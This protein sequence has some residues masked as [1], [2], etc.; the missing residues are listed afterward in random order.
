MFFL[1]GV[2]NL[3]KK[4]QAIFEGGPGQQNSCIGYQYTNSLSNVFSMSNQDPIVR[5]ICGKKKNT[6]DGIQ[7]L[8]N[9]FQED[10]SKMNYYSIVKK[11]YCAT[12]DNS[13]NKSLEFFDKCTKQRVNPMPSFTKIKN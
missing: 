11:G 5:K 13:I 8:N 6:T 9:V 1:N 7:S 2:L 12:Q 3:E 10:A 4:L